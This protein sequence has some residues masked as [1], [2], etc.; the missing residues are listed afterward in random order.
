[1]FIVLKRDY[2]AANTVIGLPMYRCTMYNVHVPHPL[3]SLPPVYYVYV[4]INCILGR[5]SPGL[6]V[7]FILLRTVREQL[8]SFGNAL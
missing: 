5:I 2:V 7:G 8:Y 6:Q 4:Y 1:M 3:T